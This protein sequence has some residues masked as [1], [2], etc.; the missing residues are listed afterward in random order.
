MIDRDVLL[1]FAQQAGFGGIDRVRLISKL[2]AFAGF[3]EDH[4]NQVDALFCSRLGDDFSKIETEF[5]DGQMDGAYQ[6]AE[7]LR[8]SFIKISSV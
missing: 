1:S 3:I 7:K 5:A 8:K 6:C 4:Q 2:T